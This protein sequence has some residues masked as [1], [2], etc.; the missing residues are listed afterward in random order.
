MLLRNKTAIVTGS[1]RGIG[2]AILQAFAENGARV[3]ACARAESSEFSDL[4]LKIKE[5]TRS[6]I[7]PFYFDLRSESE[8]NSAIQSIVASKTK[9][10]VLVNNAGI[11]AGG[12]F[13][14]TPLRNVRDVFETNFFSQIQFTQGLSRYMA[15]FKEG[16]IINIGSTAGLIGNPGTTS[17]GSSKAA[18]MFATKSIASELGAFNIRVNSIAPGIV[19]TDMFDQMD[20]KVRT[21]Q[22]EGTALR[23]PAEPREIAGVALFLA[24][25]LSTYLTGQVLRVDG[26]MA[27]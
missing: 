22:I 21:R 27:T 14:M 8:I 1:S 11:A 12:L 20:E 23:R 2:R 3:F 24:S 19:K 15:R 10:D 6:E 16:S 13:Q 26:G 5:E 4:I 17:Y 9:I 25:D 7:R 18:L